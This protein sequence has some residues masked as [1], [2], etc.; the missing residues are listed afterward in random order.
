MQVGAD[1]RQLLLRLGLCRIGCW[2][3]NVRQL[4]TVSTSQRHTRDGTG[5]SERRAAENAPLLSRVEPSTCS[6]AG[7]CRRLSSSFA[8]W[9]SSE[10][11]TLRY[12]CRSIG[13]RVCQNSRARVWSPCVEPRCSPASRSAARACAR[14]RPESRFNIPRAMAERE[15]LCSPARLSRERNGRT[16][17][18]VSERP[19]RSFSCS[20]SWEACLR[21]TGQAHA[22]KLLQYLAHLHLYALL[23]AR[24][25]LRGNPS[26][27][28]SDPCRFWDPQLLV[29]SFCQLAPGRQLGN[30]AAPGRATRPFHRPALAPPSTQS[31]I[32]LDK[33]HVHPLTLVGW[34]ESLREASFLSESRMQ[35]SQRTR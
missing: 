1:V 27:S 28:L 3:A 26:R 25:R 15:H 2:R 7:A 22:L 35:R 34:T 19:P 13:F 31:A 20:C 16:E 29:L 8:L 12:R 17:D 6:F 5:A 23:P 24:F 14:V 30:P 18:V 10:T 9:S 4:P 21:D 32:R 33:P 11:G